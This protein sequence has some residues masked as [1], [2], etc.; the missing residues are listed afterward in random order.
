MRLLLSI[1]TR[2]QQKVEMLFPYNRSYDLD[3]VQ[4]RL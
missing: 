4:Q 1:N 3:S 2:V